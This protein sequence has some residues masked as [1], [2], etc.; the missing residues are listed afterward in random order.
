MDKMN[1]EFYKLAIKITK[2]L[3]EMN[4][5]YYLKCF[6]LNDN[7]E[8][9]VYSDNYNKSTYTNTDLRF[10]VDQNSQ[11]KILNVIDNLFENSLVCIKKNKYINLVERYLLLIDD[12]PTEIVYSDFYKRNLRVITKESLTKYRDHIIAINI[13][14]LV[15]ATIINTCLKEKNL[16]QPTNIQLKNI[17]PISIN[18]NSDERFYNEIM[19]YYNYFLENK[20][21]LFLSVYNQENN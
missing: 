17:N 2:C 12:I 21:N 20:K 7:I 16:D 3:K 9:L 15:D 11:V 4:E 6:I 18:K 14:G 1:I 19:N 10:F 8:T 5:Y 13:F